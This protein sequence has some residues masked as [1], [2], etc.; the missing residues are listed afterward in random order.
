MSIKDKEDYN[1]WREDAA[2]KKG[3]KRKYPVAR[4]GNGGVEKYKP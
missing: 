1:K 2:E 4:I 3:R